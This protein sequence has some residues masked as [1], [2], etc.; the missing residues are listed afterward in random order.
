V[1]RHS[2]AKGTIRRRI[3]RQNSRKNYIFHAGKRSHGPP[4]RRLDPNQVT[5]SVGR[6]VAEL[7]RHRGLTQEELAVELGSTFQWVSQVES[8]SRNMTIHTLV[9]VANALGVVPTA[10]FETPVAES[11]KPRPGRPRKGT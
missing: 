11:R 7:R 4:V 3:R 6:R 5:E 1:N 2:G 10:L 8:G 9:K